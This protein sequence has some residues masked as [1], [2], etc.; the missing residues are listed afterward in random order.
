MKEYGFRKFDLVILCVMSSG[1]K[2]TESTQKEIRV[3]VVGC[4]HGE[5]DIIFNE[6]RQR[7]NDSKVDLLLCCGDFQVSIFMGLS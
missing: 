3:A 1:D 7:E 5:L 6:I 2:V 4:S